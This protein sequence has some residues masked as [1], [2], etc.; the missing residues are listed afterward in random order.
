M[1][2]KGIDC[3]SRFLVG[4]NTVDGEYVGLGSRV[5]TA[6]KEVI[7]Y[8][9]W[10]EYA[11]EKD[12]TMNNGILTGFSGMPDDDGAVVIPNR[13]NGEKVTAIGENAFKDCLA[14]TYYIPDTVETIEDN[15]FLNCTNLK[16]VYMSDNLMN[17]T[18]SAFKGC[19]NFETLHLNAYFKPKHAKEDISIVSGFTIVIF[20]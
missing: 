1:R 13:V 10:K 5:A 16:E 4:W 3:D 15:A 17:I 7:L 9:V 12:F 8:P 2:A 14:K 20:I 11:S 6:D 18:D 19:A